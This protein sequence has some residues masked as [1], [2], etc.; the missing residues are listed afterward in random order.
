MLRPAFSFP[1]AG[2]LTVPLKI[3]KAD[4]VQ[5]RVND[6]ESQMLTVQQPGG[7][8]CN[9]EPGKM[10]EIETKLDAIL[11][12]LAEIKSALTQLAMSQAP[13]PQ[14]PQKSRKR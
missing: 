9:V 14:T 2:V 1:T 13:Q 11:R 6:L 8:P 4:M 5:R 12:E 7:E 10:E 3:T